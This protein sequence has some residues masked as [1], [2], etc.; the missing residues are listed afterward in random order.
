MKRIIMIGLMLLS[1]AL[2]SCHKNVVK[3]DI[4]CSPPV[5]PTIPEIKTDEDL[6]IVLDI[7]AQYGIDSQKTIKC[8]EESLK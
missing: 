8:Y 6:L 4:Y 1:V 2:I 7:L 3:G 5:K